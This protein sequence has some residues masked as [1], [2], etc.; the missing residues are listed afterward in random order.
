MSTKTDALKQLH[1]A[2]Q[3]R[4]N[5]TKALNTMNKPSST[6]EVNGKILGF[7]LAIPLT[8]AFLYWYNYVLTGFHQL[9]Y[10]QACVIGMTLAILAKAN[11]GVQTL[12]SI[13]AIS[14]IVGQVGA[15]CGL[16]SLPLLQYLR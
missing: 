12:L 10:W 15:W 4:N 14:A 5:I 3:R 13:I 6:I 11:K 8:G 9:H 2:H 16:W 7:L 1:D